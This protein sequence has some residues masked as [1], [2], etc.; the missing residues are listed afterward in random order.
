MHT[1]SIWV[2]GET[3]GRRF[4]LFAEAQVVQETSAAPGR[5]TCRNPRL[6]R[7]NHQGEAA[8][9]P[10]CLSFHSCHL[11]Y[12]WSSLLWK[13]R[14]TRITRIQRPDRGPLCAETSHAGRPGVNLV[15]SAA[16]HHLRSVPARIVFPFVS[17]VSFVVRSS[18][19][20]TNHTNYTNTETGPEIAL[21]RDQSCR[22]VGGDF[23]ASAA[24]AVCGRSPPCWSVHSRGAWSAVTG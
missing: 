7:E 4:G 5:P 16:L 3:R 8:V 20:T 22:S 19:E 12:S 11:C 24:P 9:R 18:L 15:A 21:R 13:P 14:I 6:H 10:P 23:L 2:L 1:F 17:F